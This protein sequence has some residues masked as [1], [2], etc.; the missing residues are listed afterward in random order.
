MARRRGSSKGI[1]R[2][3]ERRESNQSHSKNKVDEN[4]C[5]LRGCQGDSFPGY[6]D[7]ISRRRER[8]VRRVT[9]G[10]ARH[11]QLP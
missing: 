2:A 10:C 3:V 8:D 9:S 5:F 11:L 6:A 1:G 4:T 7:S